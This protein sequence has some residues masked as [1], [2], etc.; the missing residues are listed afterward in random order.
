MV[1]IEFDKIKALT[2]EF[3]DRPLAD[4][5]SEEEQIGRAHV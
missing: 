1:D 5:P 2:D 3:L 4:F